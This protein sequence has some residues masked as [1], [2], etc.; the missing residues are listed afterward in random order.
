MA[1]IR[2]VLSTSLAF[3]SLALSAAAVSCLS[4]VS[5]PVAWTPAAYPNPA[6]AVDK[7]G[8]AGRVSRICDPDGVLLVEDANAVEGALKEL[9]LPVPPYAAA[10][11]SWLPTGRTG[12]E[13]GLRSIASCQLF[14]GQC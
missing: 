9:V 7:C 4:P 1:T 2:R 5:P 3:L 12:F 14:N 10:P 13:V 11:C 6:V 8:R